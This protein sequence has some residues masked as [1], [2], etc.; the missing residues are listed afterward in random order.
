MEGS[1][2][3]LNH[4]EEFKEEKQELLERHSKAQAFGEK[5]SSTSHTGDKKYGFL[6]T[7]L[8][9]H[10]KPAI[11]ST[12]LQNNSARHPFFDLIRHDL[13]FLLYLAL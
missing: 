6:V 8:Q 11:N 2:R 13:K 5:T 3:K 7:Y 1:S 10:F 4:K 12:E 9:K